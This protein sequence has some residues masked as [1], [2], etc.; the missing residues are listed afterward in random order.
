M[1]KSVGGRERGGGEREGE[2]KRGRT[3][4]SASSHEFESAAAP[5]GASRVRDARKGQ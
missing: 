2:R 4:W 1:R 5:C 3:G